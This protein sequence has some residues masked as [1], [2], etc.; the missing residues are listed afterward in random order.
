MDEYIKRDKILSEIATVMCKDCGV[1]ADL[2][3]SEG[4]N[5]L[6]FSLRNDEFFEIIDRIPAADVRENVRGEWLEREDPNGDSYY[7]C[8]N[9]LDEIVTC[10][11]IPT[12]WDIKYCPICGSMNSVTRRDMR[13]ESE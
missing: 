6:R 7:I 13:E 2:C 8:S 10:D 1:D 4:R 12:D 5:C 11:G 9:C 3:V